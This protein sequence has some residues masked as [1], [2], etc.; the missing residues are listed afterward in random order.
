MSDVCR[1]LHERANTSRR[2][3]F[4]LDSGALPSDGVYVV[5][6]NGER[7]HGGDRIVR[8]GSHRGAGQLPGRLAEHYLNENKD[9]SIFRKNV[10]R[11][12][13][14][15]E[16]D[17]FLDHWNLDLTSR[18]NRE[19]YEDVV[20]AVVQAEVERRVS[21]YI[22][23]SFSFAIIALPDGE[24]RRAIETGLIGTVYRCHECGASEEWLG[25]HSPKPKIR[26]SG[27]WQEQGFGTA[28]L[29]LPDV[30]G[31]DFH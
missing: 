21:L 9:R 18:E 14:A 27:L 20:D 15:R 25:L 19:R 2:Y 31:L 23:T 30:E 26:A 3:R 24:E 28:S 22:R 5:F 8:T 4:P 6:E 11:A 29:T 1:R 16:N 12:L 17:P 7:A 13:L 10:G